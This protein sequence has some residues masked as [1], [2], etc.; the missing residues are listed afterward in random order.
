[1]IYSKSAEKLP[2]LLRRWVATSCAASLQK[3]LLSMTAK[4]TSWK[5]ARRVAAI[6]SLCSPILT[7]NASPVVLCVQAWGG[8]NVEIHNNGR[9]GSRMDK[10]RERGASHVIISKWLRH[11][12]CPGS[13]CSHHYLDSC[14]QVCASRSQTWRVRQSSM[15][16][17]AAPISAE[18]FALAIH[19]LNVALLY[20]KAAEIRNSIF[21]LQTSNGHL[22]PYANEGDHDCAEA[23]RENEATIER[24]NERIAL[25]KAEVERRGM[26]W[27]ETAAPQEDGDTANGIV[28]R[29]RPVAV[30]QDREEQ[31]RAAILRRAEEAMRENDHENEGVEL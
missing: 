2:V 6:P 23:I 11:F 30:N 12:P 29:Q 3:S 8:S 5:M 31:E 14:G 7:A 25:L 1:M 4:W 17:N 19:D 18:A 26:M 22:I 21:H 15:S 24:M 28:G 16:S 10:D 27:H 9:C 20:S 13:I